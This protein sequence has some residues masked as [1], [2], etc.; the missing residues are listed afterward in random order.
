M[1]SQI[2]NYYRTGK[3]HYPTNVCGPLFEAELEF[4]GLDSNQ[5]EPCCWK[6]Y[7]KHRDTEETLATLERLALDDEK[8]S[9]EELAKMF[10]FEEEFNEFMR[11]G[12]LPWYKK[13]KPIVWQMFNEPYSSQTAKVTFN[14]KSKIINEYLKVPNSILDTHL[15][16][17]ILYRSIN[18]N[19]LFVYGQLV[20]SEYTILSSIYCRSRSHEGVGSV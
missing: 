20:L 6:T 9:S 12:Q 19:L 18:L 10:G 8:T 2:L 11:G 4:W 3:L 14:I 17:N 13:T 16:F 1:F 5:V 7:T 15:H